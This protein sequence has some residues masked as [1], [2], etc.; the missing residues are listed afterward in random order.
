MD[1]QLL[2]SMG[3]NPKAYK[4]SIHSSGITCSLGRGRVICLVGLI[5][6][7]GK[8]SLHEGAG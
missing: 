4:D 5:V 6:P 3:L 7:H 8:V 1:C 2:L